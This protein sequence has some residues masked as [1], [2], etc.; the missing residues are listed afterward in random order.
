MHGLRFAVGTLTVFPVRVTRVDSGVAGPAMLL[1][2][3]VGLVLGVVASVPLLLPGPPLLGAALAAGTLAVLTRGLHLDGLADLADGLGSGRPA[4]QALAV[5]RKSDIG[6]FGVVTLVLTLLV[7]V[8]AL[9]S[10]APWALLTACVTGRLALTWA[11]RSGVPAARPDGLGALVAGT[12]RPAAAW[13]VTLVALVAGAA[14]GLAVPASGTSGTSGAGLP[15]VVVLPL[16]TLAGL[17]ATLLLLAHARR[18]LGGVTGDV[19]GALAE[20]ATTAA[21]V[22]CAVLG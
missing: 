11:C 5:M 14:L 9:S 15:A 19:L 10:A 1:A 17:V 21:L 22:V 20:T 8:A 18:R 2:P 4:G 3:V 7:Q 16:A 12:V 13:L 6:P